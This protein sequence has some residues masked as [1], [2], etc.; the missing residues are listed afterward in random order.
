MLYL[1]IFKY[2]TENVV[3]SNHNLLGIPVKLNV[4]GTYLYYHKTNCFK[5]IID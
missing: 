1:H 4:P 2:F 3:V 5:Y